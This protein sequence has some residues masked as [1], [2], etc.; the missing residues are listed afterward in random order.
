VLGNRFLQQVFIVIGDYHFFARCSGPRGNT[1][2]VEACTAVP[3]YTIATL[4]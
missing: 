4:S 3:P 2:T 1:Q